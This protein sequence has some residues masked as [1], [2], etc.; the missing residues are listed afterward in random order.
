MVNDNAVLSMLEEG[1]IAYSK[2][3]TLATLGDRQT[4]LG[5]SD[6]ALG[7]SCP[8]AVLADKLSPEDPSMS[9]NKLLQLQR[10]HWLETGIEQ[11]FN[12]TGTTFL[13]QL[14]ISVERLRVPIKAHLDF[15][16]IDPKS[17]DVT[18]L[19]LKS[20]LRNIAGLD[21]T[22]LVS[23]IESSQKTGRTFESLF[24]SP[25]ITPADNS[26]ADQKS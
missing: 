1:L 16:L 9:L 19:E 18:V 13:S 23:V 2:H 11:A 15:T 8:R 25:I 5:M 22:V 26:W 17:N 7:L 3:H 21:E 4:Y 20:N 24:F 6:L 10:G 14:E 12:T